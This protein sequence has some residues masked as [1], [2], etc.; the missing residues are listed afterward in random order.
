[1]TRPLI[2][3]MF[4]ILSGC[5]LHA[6]PVVISGNAPSYAG[7]DLIFCTPADYISYTEKELSRCKISSSGDFRLEIPINETLQ[8]FAYLGVFKAVL[9]IEP[10]QE[11]HIVLPEKMEK[12]PEEILNPFF[13]PVE[14]HLGLENF[15]EDELNTLIMM[16]NDSY[17]PYYEKHVNDIYIKSQPGRID[18]D[19]EQIEKSFRKYSD[20][21]FKAYRLYSYGELKLLANQQKVRSLSQEYFTGKPVLYFHPAYMKLFDQVYEKYFTF[22][23]RSDAGKKIY[24]DINRLNSF[25]ALLQTLSAD[26][27]IN[28]DTLRELV[29]L[30]SIYDE[31]YGMEFSRNGLLTLLDSLIL[32]SRIP[33]HKEIGYNIRHKITRLQPGYDP[34]LFELY[35]A[36]S[37]LVRLSDLKGKYVY[38][39]FCTSSSYTCINEFELLN[40]IYQRHH[41]RLTIITIS[42]DPHESTFNQFKS[43]NNYNWIFLYYGHQPDVIK[44]Y[45]IRAYPTY[46]L[47]GPDGKLIYSPAPSPSENFEIKLFEAMRARGDL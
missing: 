1:M 11:Y 35:D 40:G 38:I 14:I 41:Q 19:I 27:N 22:F 10:H 36:D 25:T 9:L 12:S 13:E 21:F 47:I 30:K 34:P 5:L 32:T 20:P 31:F 17:I 43:N 26:S 2:C 44:E 7:L 18:E 33:I 6:Q 15:R 16:F 24:N 42:T 39:N 37:N 46:F 3:A 8:V 23:A 4:L 29:I 28:N 45:D